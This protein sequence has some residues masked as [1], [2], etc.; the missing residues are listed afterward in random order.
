MLLL[1]GWH[2]LHDAVNAGVEITA[3]ALAGPPLSSRDARVIERLSEQCDVFTVTTA[4]MNA[5]SPVRTPSG[6]VALAKRRHHSI[7]R[8]L[9]PAPTLLVIAVSIQDPG[10][11][12]AI[13]RSAEAG[14]ATGVLFLGASADPWGWKALRAAMGSSLRLAVLHHADVADGMAQVRAAGVSVLGSVPRGGVSMHE[15]N[16][17]G[18]VALVVGSEGSG[19]DGD[20][21]AAADALVS[22]PMR[23]PVES[24]NVA[25]A[26]ALLVYEARRQR[27]A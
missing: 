19:L 18:S 14:G 22:I 2:L 10:N 8:L 21:R 26:T 17:C 6:V 7:A 11:V 16:M 15:A 13:V 24:L 5:M 1:D 23:E 12:G 20:L 25:V 3:V 9:S 27:E 4:V